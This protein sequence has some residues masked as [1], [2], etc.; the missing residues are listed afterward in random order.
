MSSS[1]WIQE[2]PS[3][4]GHQRNNSISWIIKAPP[5]CSSSSMNRRKPREIS[6]VFNSIFFTFMIGTEVTNVVVVHSKWYYKNH[7]KVLLVLGFG[8]HR[9][10]AAR[11]QLSVLSESFCFSSQS[12]FVSQRYNVQA[13]QMHGCIRWRS[14]RFAGCMRRIGSVLHYLGSQHCGNLNSG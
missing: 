2:F 14:I 6:T 5:S 4:R 9:L 8:T 10:Y 1:T 12:S 13:L 7:F 3:Q 11:N